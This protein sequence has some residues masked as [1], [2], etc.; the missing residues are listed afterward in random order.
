MFSLFPGSNHQA[1]NS[2][3]Q[4]QC[5]WTVAL[6][7]CWGGTWVLPVCS[8]LY[9]P[10]SWSEDLLQGSFCSHRILLGACGSA[11]SSAHRV[12][13]LGAS[14]VYSGT[15]ASC[16][17]LNPGVLPKTVTSEGLLPGL[18]M[19]RC[20]MQ[21]GLPS[22]AMDSRLFCWVTSSGLLGTDEP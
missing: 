20:P 15:K 12:L 14:C 22:P 5:L 13:N 10:P 17:L 6:L 9:V 21:R 2:G 7:Y 4:S 1:Q 8:S 11:C 3:S 18:L 16:S 19:P